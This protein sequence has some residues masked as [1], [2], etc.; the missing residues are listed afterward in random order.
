M[1]MESQNNS[2]KPILEQEKQIIGLI[3][4]AFPDVQA[5]YLFGTYATQAFRPDSDVDIAI[6]LPPKQAKEVGFLGMSALRSQLEE[7]LKRTVDLINLRHVPTI[8][9][10]EAL[11]ADRQI[12]CADE[13]ASAEFEM[14]SLSFYQKLNAERAEIIQDILETKRIIV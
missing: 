7:V 1:D 9:Q 10:I 6:L 13:Y 2:S 11:K 12:Y 14:L 5:I 4:T 3:V 8:L